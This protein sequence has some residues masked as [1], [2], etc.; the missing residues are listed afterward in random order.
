MNTPVSVQYKVFTIINIDISW[1]G[2]SNILFYIRFGP[3][4]YA[5]QII[6]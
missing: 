4:K 2:N 3:D 5:I 1:N 6:L